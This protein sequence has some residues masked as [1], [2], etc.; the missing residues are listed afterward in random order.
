MLQVGKAGDQQRLGCPPVA[1]GPMAEPLRSK[2]RSRVG[3][4][5]L[6]SYYSAAGSA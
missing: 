4:W 3:P 1:G 2:Q 6:R 5:T